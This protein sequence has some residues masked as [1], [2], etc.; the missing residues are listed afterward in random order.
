[1]HLRYELFCNNLPHLRNFCN[2][3]LQKPIGF[4]DK[5]M[6]DDEAEFHFAKWN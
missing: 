3:F 4:E 1:M 5:L 2:W 6:I